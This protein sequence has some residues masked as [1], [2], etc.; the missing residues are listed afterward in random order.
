M[1]FISFFFSP[2]HYK[3]LVFYV[4]FYLRFAVFKSWVFVRETSTQG[5]GNSGLLFL[6]WYIAVEPSMNKTRAHEPHYHSDVFVSRM[7][8]GDSFLLCIFKLYICS[9]F[10]WKLLSW[11]GSST[12]Q[13]SLYCNL[14]P[15]LVYRSASSVRKA[16]L[17]LLPLLTSIHGAGSSNRQ[18][19]YIWECVSLLHYHCPSPRIKLLNLIWDFDWFYF[20]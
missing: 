12:V 19:G 3:K 7:S 11:I 13:Y 14:Y 5:K 16:G 1:E 8:G 17:S 15:C 20:T 10:M 18:P 9:D 2:Q 6:P 4:P